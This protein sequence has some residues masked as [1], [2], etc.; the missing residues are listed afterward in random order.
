MSKSELF[1]MAFSFDL[2]KWRAHRAAHWSRRDI[3]SVLPV[4]FHREQQAQPCSPGDRRDCSSKAPSALIT[5][6]MAAQT[7]L[8][9]VMPGALYSGVEA[10]PFHT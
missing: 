8:G 7:D 2:E 6:A 10:G 4:M 3:T 5:P 1:D 9:A